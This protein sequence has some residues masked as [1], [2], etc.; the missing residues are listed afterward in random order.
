MLNFKKDRVTLLKALRDLVE[1]GICNFDVNVDLE[2]EVAEFLSEVKDRR[3]VRK[4]K[5][6]RRELD[7]FIEEVSYQKRLVEAERKHN[8]EK[9]IESERVESERAYDHQ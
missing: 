3:R 5:V 2:E 7:T 4:L 8:E 9:R 1:E 6:I